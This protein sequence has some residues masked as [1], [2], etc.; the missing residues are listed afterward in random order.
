MTQTRSNER[1]A[2]LCATFDMRMRERRIP[3]AALGILH[4]G[5][6]YY[7]GF[8]VTS[9]EHPLPVTPDTLFQCGSISK[10]VLG[11]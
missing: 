9:L 11:L 7:A 8:G 6:A 4:D 10:T 5:A 1:F 2:E 3:G